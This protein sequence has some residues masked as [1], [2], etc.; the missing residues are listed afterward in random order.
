MQSAIPST[1]VAAFIWHFVKK[2]R[3]AYFAIFV[4]S[5]IGGAMNVLFPYMGK[6]FVNTI[7]AFERA[8]APQGQL[9][10]HYLAPII[11][12]LIGLMALQSVISRM[13]NFFSNHNNPK[14]QTNI[15]MALVK[16]VSHQSWSFFTNNYAGQIAGKIDDLATYTRSVLSSLWQSLRIISLFAASLSMFFT[17]H[18]IFTL[19]CLVWMAGHFTFVRIR[20]K[21]WVQIYHERG[22][23]KAVA[24]GKTIDSISNYATVKPFASERREQSYIAP[25]WGAFVTKWRRLKR[26]TLDYLMLDLFGVLGLY[27]STFA[28]IYFLYDY[29]QIQLGDIVFVYT[30]TEFIRKQILDLDDKVIEF[31]E[32]YGIMRQGLWVVSTPVEI[33]DAS[34]AKHLSCCKAGICFDKMT[35]RPQNHKGPLFKNF[36]LNIKPGEKV[37]IVGRSGAGKSSLVYLLLRYFDVEGGAIL[38]NGQDIRGITQE[39]LRNHIA[40]ISQDTALFHRS[41]YDNIAYGKP[42]SSKRE[43]RAAAKKANVHDMIMSFPEKYETLAGDKGTRLS[44]GQRQRVVIARALLKDAPILILD[45]ATSALDSETELGIR[46]SLLELMKGRT[47]IAIAHRLSTLQGMDRIVVI[48]KGRVVEEGPHRELVK[49]K[50]GI[51]AKLWQMQSF[52]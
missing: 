43:V 50:N 31:T 3:W 5:A 42:G 9:I 15:R 21:T 32:S 17:I 10:T 29:G 37:G 22:E 36:C 44:G 24:T 4:L 48:D 52:G 41:I 38:I 34:H 30:A 49:K 40:F 45:E 47:T 18:W 2:Q 23:A 39:S 25:F 1:S 6:M 7:E 16:H 26:I 20:L 11:L 46:K 13:G 51:Y 19:I 35:F 8:G 12:P 33:R 14:L 28:A 27:L